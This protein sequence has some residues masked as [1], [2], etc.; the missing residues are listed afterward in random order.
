MVRLKECLAHMRSGYAWPQ[1][2]AQCDG[3][4]RRTY[5]RTNEEPLTLS[6]YPQLVNARRGG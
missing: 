2:V 3:R 4:N 6:N 1:C 5:V